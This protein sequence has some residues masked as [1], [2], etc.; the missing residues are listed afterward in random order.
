MIK[1]DRV[2]KA[3]EFRDIRSRS[4]LTNRQLA[5]TLGVSVSTISNWLRDG[6]VGKAEA[7][8]EE[9]LGMYMRQESPDRPLRAYT[10]VELLAELWQR[11]DEYKQK[12]TGRRQS[13]DFLG[14]IGNRPA[15]GSSPPPPVVDDDADDRD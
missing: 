3:Q 5:K 7:D 14:Q 6:V 15:P 9:K 2:I 4:R 12:S 8:V 10:D 1:M 13:G 11:M